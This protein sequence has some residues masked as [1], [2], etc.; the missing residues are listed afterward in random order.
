MWQKLQLRKAESLRLTGSLEAVC[1]GVSGAVDEWV[2]VPLE[3]VECRGSS[4]TVRMRSLCHQSPQ[5][6]SPRP[7]HSLTCSPLPW[8][9]LLE[10]LLHSARPLQVP[11][12]PL[13]CSHVLWHLKEATHVV[14]RRPVQVLVRQLHLRP[15]SPPWMQRQP[16]P[17]PIPGL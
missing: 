7:L 17:K 9:L 1:A 2:D 14:L 12:M 8:L 15:G 5:L 10:I 4:T 13:C 16:G 3:R 11:P 6:D